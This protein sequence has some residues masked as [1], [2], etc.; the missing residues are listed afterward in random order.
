MLDFRQVSQLNSELAPKTYAISSN[1][2][3]GADDADRSLSLMLRKLFKV[4]TMW[5][6]VILACALLLFGLAYYYVSNTT[7][8]YESAVTLEVNQEE[9]QILDVS[10]IESVVA[11]EE[12]LTTQ[13]ELLRSKK[14]ARNV[15]LGLD[16]MS[17]STFTPYM[18]SGAFDEK[19][20]RLTKVVLD[21]LEVNPVGRSRLIELS[22]TDP[23]P[24]KAADIANGFVEQFIGNELNTKADSTTYAR[25]FLQHQLS[26]IERSL[27]QAERELVEYASNNSLV[28]T[29]S[30]D[31]N[32]QTGS[33][34][35]ASLMMLNDQLTQARSD[36][37]ATEIEFERSKT[38]T[39]DADL[40]DSDAITSLRAQRVNLNANYV[41]K[42]T[43]LKP[44]HP[45]MQ[46]LQNQI[47]LI[48]ERVVAEEQ[49]LISSRR[50]TVEERYN[51]ALGIEQS[52]MARVA[53]VQEAVNDTREKSITYNILKRQVETE[54]TQYEALLQRL[55]EV[56]LS[57]DIGYN[58]IEIV[59][60]AEVTTSPVS[61]QK[62]RIY[63]LAIILGSTIG[64]AISYVINL[65]NDKIRSPDDVSERLNVP[66]IGVIPKHQ[67]ARS[68]KFID[69]L[70]SAQSQIAEA[71]AS[72]RTSLRFMGT[73]SGPRVIQITSTQS[74]EGK[75]SSSFGL[76]TRYADM[77]E[78]VLLI[79]AD[80]RLPTF[81]NPNGSDGLAGLLV[82]ENAQISDYVQHSRIT[83]L[84][85]IPAG[86]RV[87]NPS[88]LL[89]SKRFENILNEARGQYDYV[90]VDSPPVLGIADAVVIANAV[91]STIYIVQASRLLTRDVQTALSRLTKTGA[92][93][94]GAVLTKYVAPRSGY[95]SYYQYSYGETEKTSS[96]KKSSVAK[97]KAPID[98]SSAA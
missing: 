75:S 23:D 36:R 91:D 6:W 73:N 55:K 21:N 38:N 40:V 20:R 57:D 25:N 84:D 5:W 65:F 82:D 89:S 90:V 31:G 98:L 44:G 4:V 16:L 32:E 7:P 48:D 70:V 97:K 68:D 43:R 83:N 86:R 17:D 88:E 12:F 1:F 13:I 39:F 71:F 52:L 22:Y 34:D 50:G 51:A 87:V 19:M 54:R 96:R 66:L 35:I 49:R 72:L 94:A 62:Y 93:V 18:G 8:L 28:I 56:S 14:L 9:R 42:L 79:D 92:N 30:T 78:R 67:S 69:D 74:S 76:A 27:A 41:Q 26:E 47:N 37:I 63:A 15:I 45:E 3:S 81:S 61:P 58:L 60:P 24:V 53:L 59:D 33:L 46:E 10:N 11:N 95:M 85:F 80:L 77:G 29:Q 2:E 64:F